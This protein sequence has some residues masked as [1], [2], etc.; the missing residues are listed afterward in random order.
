MLKRT[1]RPCVLSYPSVPDCSS[2]GKP[3][4][5]K[6]RKKPELTAKAKKPGSKR[7]RPQK[8]RSLE[9]ELSGPDAINS[10]ET[11]DTSDRGFS[12]SG[13]LVGDPWLSPGYDAP[14]SQVSIDIRSSPTQ[15]VAV[16]GNMESEEERSLED[17]SKVGPIF[18]PWPEGFLS[19]LVPLQG[20]EK[21]PQMTLQLLKWLQRLWKFLLY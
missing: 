18:L 9:T 5:S 15:T 1:Q 6:A 16:T 11:E 8:E 3:K 2:P 21:L 14:E 19:S 10:E 17:P 20:W 7:K 4:K 13:S 12:P